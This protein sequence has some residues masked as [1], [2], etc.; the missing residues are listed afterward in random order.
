MVFVLHEIEGQDR[1]DVDR[2]QRVQRADTRDQDDDGKRQERDRGPGGTFD[3]EAA[4]A[5]PG[6]QKQRHERRRCGREA[7]QHLA[8]TRELEQ[9]GLHPM[10][11]RRLDETRLPFERRHD[12]VATPHHF[13]RGARE[14][15]LVGVE[16]WIGA[17]SDEQQ[18]ERPGDCREDRQLPFLLQP[19]LRPRRAPAALKAGV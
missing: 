3:A 15:C 7:R 13:D 16:E 8:R 14:A 1:Q 17:E 12:V 9:R 5:D 11:K 2:Q 4:P 18:E 10:Q 19:P 6:D